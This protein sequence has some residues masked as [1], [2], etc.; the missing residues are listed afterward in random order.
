MLADNP[1]EARRVT[2]R[3][4]RP[5]MYGLAGN[6]VTSRQLAAAFAMRVRDGRRQYLVKCWHDRQWSDS[7]WIDAQGFTPL[8]RHPAQV[9]GRISEPA[10]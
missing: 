9:P 3:A 6:G 5:I 2:Q 10:L 1:E 7:A 8:R 4:G